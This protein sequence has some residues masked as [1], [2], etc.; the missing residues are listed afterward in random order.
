MSG[1]EPGQQL[2]TLEVTPE[3]PE[4][5]E[6]TGHGERVVEVTARPAEPA[7]R[8]AKVRQVIPEHGQHLALPVATQRHLGVSR[9]VPEPVGVTARDLIGLAGYSKTFGAVL[10]KRLQ[11][12]VARRRA[13]LDQDH[14]SRDEPS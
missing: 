12:A 13:P 2:P 9:D 10:P 7:Q 6:R 3:V 11:D 5:A 4:Q 1:K 14:R 8:G